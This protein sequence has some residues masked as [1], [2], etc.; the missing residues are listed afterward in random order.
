VKSAAS[1]AVTQLQH[2]QKMHYGKL[3]QGYAGTPW[4][5]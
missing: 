2:P 1:A 5:L 3:M 4:V